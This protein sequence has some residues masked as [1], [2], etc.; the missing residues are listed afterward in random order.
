[1]KPPSL[2][3]GCSSGDSDTSSPNYSLIGYIRPPEQL[4]GALLLLL[5]LGLLTLSEMDSHPLTV[6]NMVYSEEA[7]CL[8]TEMEHCSEQ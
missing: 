8:S 6:F 7:M 2:L 4:T 5:L 3:L 1:M